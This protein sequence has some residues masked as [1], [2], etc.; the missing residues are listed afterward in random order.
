MS[1]KTQNI[2]LNNVEITDIAAEGKAIA[3]VDGKIIFVPYAIPGSIVD[4]QIVRK[5]RN[6]LEGKIINIVK[7][8]D[9]FVDAFCE[10]FGVCGGCKWQNLPYNEQLFY[11][12]K[13]VADQLQRIGKLE[14]P[15]INTI[16]ASPK[17]TEYRNK[18]EFTFSCK[19]WITQREVDENAIIE[20]PNAL[21]FHI[22]QLFD[23]V[24]NIN[25]CYLQPEPSNAIR[26]A[27]YDFAIENNYSF[28]DIRE[29]HGFLRNLIIRNTKRGAVMVIV[30][31]AHDDETKRCV[32]LD[33]LQN[34]FSQ[35]SSLQYVINAKLNDSIND[36]EVIRYSGNDFLIEEMSGLQFKIAAKS[37]YQTNPEQVL[38]LYQTVFDFAGVDNS[39][40]VYDLYTG[41]GTIALFLAR[42][43]KKV[44]GIEY[45]AEAI[46]DAKRNAE[47][48]KIDN[49]D[50]YVGD[51]KDVLTHEFIDANGKA[52]IIILDPP[53]AGIHPKVGEV[54]L[55]AQPQKIVYV[56]CNPATQA[57]DLTAL[58][59]NYKISKIQPVDMFP[60]TQH[61]ENVVM[62][63]KN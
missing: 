41:T 56:S 59:A 30:V 26:K 9:K 57:R 35:I 13:Q 12:Q 61:V 6:F 53:R 16:I 48:N 62:L 40:T 32:L 25:H 50:F 22:P 29:K 28:F 49:V 45:V 44:I 51:M 52:D 23:K 24:L 3:K 8:S 11:K 63:V 7:Q 38:N 20:N 55:K 46:A 37:F 10:H 36:L 42:Q 19:R 2:I 21:G 1:R 39:Q 47:I 60:H 54:I 27:V 17:T 4:V 58:T 43:A 31:F 15:E 33:Y 34:K 5:Q 18:L 14:L